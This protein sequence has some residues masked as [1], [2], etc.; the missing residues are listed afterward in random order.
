MSKWADY[1]ISAVRYNS[2]HTHIDKVRVH[3]DSG[4]SIGSATEK[5]RTDVIAAIKKGETFVTIMMNSNGKW[6]KGQSVYIIK[7]NGT[8]FIKT[9]DN[10]KLADN[11]DSLPE[12]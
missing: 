12:F 7:V 11:L 5:N 6:N 9:V 10:N 8:E 4:D 2:A 3:V 1:G